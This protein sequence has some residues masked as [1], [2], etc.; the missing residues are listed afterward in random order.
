M[1]TPQWKAIPTTDDQAVRSLE[2]ALNIHP[3]LCQLLVQRGIDTPQQAEQFFHPNWASLHDPFLMQDMERAVERLD[4]ALS[5]SENILIYGDYDV[6]GTMSVSLLFD[7]LQ[8][9]GH[10]QL[11]YYFPDRY[12]EGYGLSAEGIAYAK[13]NGVSLLITVD[14]GIRAQEQV[15]NAR[16]QGMDVIIC[17]HHLP[18][19]N[20]PFA[21]AVLDPKR[22][23]CAYPYKELSGCGIAFKLAQG[24]LHYRQQSDEQLMLYADFVAISIA[25]DIVPITG[26]NRI[27]AHYGL[28]AINRTRRHGLKALIKVSHRRRPILISD[29]VFGLGPII[30]AA[31]RMADAG[32]V[33]KLML[34]DT[35]AIASSYAEALKQRNEQRREY[36]RS[37]AEEARNSVLASQNWEEN[38]SF[39]LYQPH[40]HPGI[41][42]IVAAR[43]ANDF[44]RP[45]IILTQS[46]DI[47]VGSVRSAGNIDLFPAIESCK[48]LLLSYGGHAFAAGLSMEEDH[49]EVFGQRFEEFIRTQ[50]PERPL[51]PTVEIAGSLQLED[52]SSKFY[53]QLR[54]F[55][56]FGPGNLNPTFTTSQVEVNGPMD[57]LKEEHLRLSLKQGNSAPIAAIGF[58]KGAH[59]SELSEHAN[60]GICYS[61][62]EN[63]W[64]GKTTLQLVIKD[65]DFTGEKVAAL[66]WGAVN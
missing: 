40:W 43:L 15:D 46:D 36:D 19:E 5:R 65:F 30:N 4:L 41:I 60:F 57:L 27:L 33:V 8:Q 59:F 62:Q 16:S 13:A 48:D 2:G 54:Q 64:R 10:R 42:G 61:L 38:A 35:R 11:D 63:H 3:L 6:D 66:E 50:N 23:D 21:T 51:K 26:E 52:I 44:H 25:A 24:L 14:C 56:P 18:G 39:V 47:L 20:W 55:A 22:P 29:I 1:H 12:K 49:W 58:G 37:A 9:I 32:T 17:D 34:A 53:R 45:T 7:F 31:G 28:K